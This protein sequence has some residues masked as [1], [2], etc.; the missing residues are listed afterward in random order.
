MH[1]KFKQQLTN[2]TYCHHLL[3]QSLVSAAEYQHAVCGYPALA[4]R[5]LQ[6][7]ITLH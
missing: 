3:N 1:S 6:P 5:R 4:S 7:V 2:A